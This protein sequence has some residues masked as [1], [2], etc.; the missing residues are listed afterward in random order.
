VVFRVIGEGHAA[1]AD[2]MQTILT[3][4]DNATLTLTGG[5]MTGVYRDGEPIPTFLGDDYDGSDIWQ[6]AVGYTYHAE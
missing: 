5:T 4:F 1:M 3:A 2:K 6:W